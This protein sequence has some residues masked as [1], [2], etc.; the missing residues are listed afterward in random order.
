MTTGCSH[1]FCERVHGRSDRPGSDRP[2]DS[3]CKSVE[4]TPL[5][6]T[7]KTSNLLRCRISS[8]QSAPMSNLQCHRFLDNLRC[9]F[10]F[11][12]RRTRLKGKGGKDQGR[13][14]DLDRKF[15]EHPKTRPLHILFPLLFTSSKIESGRLLVRTFTESILI[16]SFFLRGIRHRSPTARHDVW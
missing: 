4:W 15:I 1:H 6:F 14:K 9:I 3:A 16:L 2:G 8:V 7:Q 11:F 5:C 13:R 12:F 10:E